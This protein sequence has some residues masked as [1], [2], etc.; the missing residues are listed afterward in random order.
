[1]DVR[2]LWLGD[3]LEVDRE[4]PGLRK[5]FKAE[6]RSVGL[7]EANAFGLVAAQAAYEHGADWLAQLKS[8]LEE[9]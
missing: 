2:P 7:D 3:G 9:T 1:M 5:R 6:Y 4:D 8:Y